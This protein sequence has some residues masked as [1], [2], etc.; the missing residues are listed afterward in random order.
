M[1]KPKYR[2]D[3]STTK[4]FF[5]WIKERY[6]IHNKRHVLGE[7]APWTTD[8]VLQTQFFT[9]P[10][11]EDDK[12]TRWFRDNIRGPLADDDDVL[13]ATLLFRWF[14][15]IPTGEA[16]LALAEELYPHGD[17][18]IL[19][20]PEGFLDTAS[21]ILDMLDARQAAG[22]RLFGG[23]YIIKLANGVRKHHSVLNTLSDLLTRTGYEV[24]Q[25]R[26]WNSP[27]LEEGHSYLCQLPY[28]GP[29]M[30]YEALTDLRHTCYFR[31]APD[32]RTW[33][34]PGPGAFRGLRRLLGLP[35][36]KRQDK[37]VPGGKKAAIEMMR[38]LL[39]MAPEF[40]TI[41]TDRQMKTY[42]TDRVRFAKNY[43]AP[44]N[45]QPTLP[46]L[47]MRDIEH[48][49]CEFDKYERARTGVGGKMKRKFTKGT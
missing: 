13:F 9:N 28:I 29:F 24:L 47:E 12:V 32:I 45:V 6:S 11:R 14:N 23:A 46:Q 10:F 5:Y 3:K 27:T 7:P 22:E 37:S 39:K 35:V 25:E 21:D 8:M 19:F 31:E 41:A 26:L 30:A 43:G 34:N 1:S 17:P 49:L 15:S 18:V 44:K 40:L 2:Y 36:E 4:R 38:G 42:E 33:A 20:T 48:S 16:I